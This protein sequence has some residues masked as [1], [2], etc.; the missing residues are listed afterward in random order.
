MDLLF[1]PLR[2]G[3]LKLGNRLVFLPFYLAYPDV[4]NQVNDL[5]L[6]HYEEMAASGVGLVVVENASVEPCGL[7]LPRTLLVSDDRFLLRV[8]G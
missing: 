7:G 6:D 1:S 4:D 3:G 5:V 8:E 2:V